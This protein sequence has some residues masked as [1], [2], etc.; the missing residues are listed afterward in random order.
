MP[1][2]DDRHAETTLRVAGVT[3]RFGDR[4]ALDDVGL[5]VLSG[6]FTALLGVNGAGKTTL[7]NLVTGL[8]A[9]RTGQIEVCGHD[10]R[11]TPRQA[12]ARMGVVFQSRSLD[13]GL[14][15]RQ[16][17][18]Y[19][20][21]LH[22]LGRRL[23]DARAEELLGRMGLAALY[24]RKV[25]TLSG[26]EAR[27]VEIARALLHAPRLLLCDEATVGLDVRAR[28]DI[29]AD[30]HRLAAETGAGVLWA[31]HLIDEIAAE[32]P[33]VVLHQGRVL[34]RGPA[35]EIAGGKSLSDAFLALTGKSAA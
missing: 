34:A 31:T 8:Y 6:R 12:L 14:T 4:V 20:G 18:L 26:G 28:T 11:T 10:I 27:R 3:H 5:E 2:D 13:A 22:G 33:V 15:V 9:S 30:L 35:A 1:P 25:A 17:F 29:V 23:I 24:G 19:Q 21:A 7:F 32:D 16:N